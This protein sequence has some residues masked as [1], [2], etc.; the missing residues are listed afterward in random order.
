MR[1][2]QASGIGD[3]YRQE[4]YSLAKDEQTKKLSSSKSHQGD[5][6]TFVS[7]SKEAMHAADEVK[8]SKSNP[9]KK[10]DFTDMSQT[11]L[12]GAARSLFDAGDIS[13]LDMA[14]LQRVGRVVGKGG[15][16]GEFVQ[17][18]PADR[19]SVDSEHKN[20]LAILREQLSMKSNDP[21]MMEVYKRLEAALS[22]NHGVP[23]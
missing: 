9:Q 2:S 13:E 14:I 12:Q 7:F 16:N 11:Q 5:A 17:L 6:S 22:K 3:E 4:K 18:T 21:N 23:I 15:P 19:T 20:F 8:Q 1:I 10:F